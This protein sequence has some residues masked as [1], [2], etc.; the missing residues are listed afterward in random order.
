MKK[1]VRR[2]LSLFLAVLL[3]CL[4]AAPALAAED[5]TAATM[6]LMK[7]EGTVSVSGATGRGMT[8]RDNMR[9][10]N[11]YSVETKA[12]SYA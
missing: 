11:G 2:K 4:S 1:R 8:A 9:L 7:T 10:Y 6:Q 5:A 3:L 12:G